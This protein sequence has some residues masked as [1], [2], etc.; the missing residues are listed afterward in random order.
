MGQSATPAR[1]EDARRHIE[2]IER[3]VVALQA[4]HAVRLDGAGARSLRLEALGMARLDA[5]RH[6]AREEARWAEEHHLVQAILAWRQRA[7]PG[8]AADTGLADESE[9]QALQARLRQVQDGAA[10]VPLQV[11]AAV[12]A[13]IVSA[14]TGVPLGQVLRDELDTVR[15]LE[16]GLR[17][18]VVGQDHA[19]AAIARRVRTARA[20][21]EDP[22][23]PRGVFLFVGP[24]GVGK[25]ETALALADL[26]YGGERNLITI[27][28]SEYQE[29]HSVSGLKGAPPGYVGHG[30]GGVLTEAV[31]RNPHSVILL[32]EVE[33]AHPD[34]L[35]LFF[36]V[37]DKGRMDDAEGREVDF[38]QALIILT[39]NAGSAQVMQACMAHDEAAGGRVMHAPDDMPSADALAHAL[40]P[41]LSRVFKPALLGRTLVVPYHPLHDD[42]LAEVVRL[43]LARIARRMQARHGAELVIDDALVEAV[44]ARCTEVDS[45][46]RA[47]DHILTGQLLPQLADQVL[48]CLAEGQAVQRVRA[49]VGPQGEFRLSWETA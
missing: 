20:G 47:V 26:L 1:I 28:M 44:L 25:T 36:Q 10:L 18:R 37:F 23:K 11:D 35:E 12:V 5:Q 3:E 27:N 45:G 48:C 40:Q 46:A 16:A 14:W 30:Q 41:V 31:R 2:H 9:L 13:D 17:E 15:H 33:K 21:L 38:R 22:D 8:G 4:E 49:G 42:V 29:A 24:S 7:M 43:K 19:L 34:V 39:S 32:D 6:L